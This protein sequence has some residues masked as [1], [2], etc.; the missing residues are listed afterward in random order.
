MARHGWEAGRRA[1]RRRVAPLE[2]PGRG[3]DGAGVTDVHEPYENDMGG[4][5]RGAVVRRTQLVEAAAS[6]MPPVMV[7]I[8]E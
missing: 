3:D 4:R 5:R 6:S 2:G 7:S 8:T 1:R